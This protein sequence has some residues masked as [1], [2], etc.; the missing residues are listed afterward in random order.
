MIEN[1][2]KAKN[3]YD[4]ELYGVQKNLKMAEDELAS[5]QEK[6]QELMSAIGNVTNLEARLDAIEEG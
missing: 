5:K 4:L 1:L 6:L 2:T 3:D